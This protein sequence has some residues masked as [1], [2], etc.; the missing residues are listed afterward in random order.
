MH[1]SLSLVLFATLAF[2]ATDREGGAT[3]SLAGMHNLRRLYLRDTT[4]AEEAMKHIS[5]LTGLEELDLYGVKVTER[6]IAYLKDL[7]EG[8]KLNLSGAPISDQSISVLA[9]MTHLQELNLYRSRITNT[10]LAGLGFM[11]AAADRCGSARRCG[12]SP[13]R[14]QAASGIGCEG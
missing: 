4:I 10:G 13:G 8:R 5:R 7:K 1:K 12:Y 2:A 6:G 11:V 9:G 14:S 3:P